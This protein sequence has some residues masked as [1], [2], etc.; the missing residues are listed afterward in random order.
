MS[1]CCFCPSFECGTYNYRVNHGSRV[2]V[3]YP[4]HS[5]IMREHAFIQ[6]GCLEITRPVREPC[7][8]RFPHSLWTW[9]KSFLH[10]LVSTGGQGDSFAPPEYL[11][12]FAPPLVGFNP[13]WRESRTA[14]NAKTQVATLWVNVICILKG[15]A[16]RKLKLLLASKCAPQV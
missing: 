12:R 9:G 3:L 16:E 13:A 11:Q 8:M 5:Y 2:P 10:V 14:L 7:S 1:R 6:L 4:Q 15:A